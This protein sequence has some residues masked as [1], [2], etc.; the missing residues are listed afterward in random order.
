[1]TVD[2]KICGIN[3]HRALAAA[4]E[5]G[6]AFV[7][8]VFYPPSPRYL[9][10]AQAASVAV[11]APAQIRKVGVFVD[12]PDRDLDLALERV[13]LDMLQLH[14]RESPARV[15]EIR[16]RYGLPVIKAIPVAAE[17]DLGAV[18][19]YAGA[20]DWLMFDAKPPRN[21]S[22][23]PGG[24]AARFDWTLLQGLDVP[25]PW[26]LSGGLDADNVAEAVRITGAQH[27][28]VSSGV[29]IKPGDKDPARIRAFL[30]AVRAIDS[31]PA[32]PLAQGG[33]GG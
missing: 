7:G 18:A 19:D 27:V 31:A 15:A 30:E 21:Q 23:L 32:K 29:E 14:G 9:T 16:A 11:E 22:S 13:A 20:A 8:F 12:V 3:S 1:M 4:V 28:D 5:G 33:Q 2:A 24:N 6:A 17:D 10:P 25:L 26:F